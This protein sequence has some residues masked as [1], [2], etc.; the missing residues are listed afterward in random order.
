MKLKINE[1]DDC[2]IIGDIGEKFTEK[3]FLTIFQSILTNYLYANRYKYDLYE[4]FQKAGKDGKTGISLFEWEV[5]TRSRFYPDILLELFHS[6]GKPGWFYYTKADIVVYLYLNESKLIEKG[7]LLIMHKLK[8]YF[9]S[10]KLDAYHQIK[11][12]SKN[13]ENEW[14]TINVAIPFKDFPKKSLISLPNL[15]T[16]KGSKFNQKNLMNFGGN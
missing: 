12:W 8:D 13:K 16:L 3:N 14:Y 2:M 1:F 9:T 15:N 10:E 5:K 11:A 7:F 6:Y 4:L